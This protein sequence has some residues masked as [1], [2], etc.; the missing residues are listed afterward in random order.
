MKRFDLRPQPWIQNVS[1]AAI[2]SGM[3]FETSDQD[4]L[5]QIVDPCTVFPTPKQTFGEVFQFIFLDTEDESDEWSISDL[6]SSKIANILLKAFADHRNVVVHC[7]AG[8]CRSGAV[9]EVGVIMGFVDPECLRIPNSLV[10]K[11]LLNSLNLGFSPK[12]SAFTVGNNI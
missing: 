5:I 12:N 8:L 1:L 9:T 4:F 2:S 10:K 11:K 3:H 7:H 6:D